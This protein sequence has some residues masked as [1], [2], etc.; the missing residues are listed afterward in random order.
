MAFSGRAAC[1]LSRFKPAI[2]G[3]VVQPPADNEDLLRVGMGLSPERRC[4]GARQEASQSGV[5]TRHRI[6]TQ[7][8]LLWPSPPDL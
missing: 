5:F 4:I 6:D 8:D 2:K 7:C 3:V 1:V